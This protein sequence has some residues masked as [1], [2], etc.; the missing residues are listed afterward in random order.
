MKLCETMAA[1]AKVPSPAC[2]AWMVQFPAASSEAVVPETVQV[3]GV[4]EAKA[5]VRPELAVA[6]R[7]SVVVATWRP[8]MAGKLMLCACPEV[9][10]EVLDAVRFSDEF[11]ARVAVS[12]SLLVGAVRMRLLKVAE[13]P[14]RLAEVVPPSSAALSV[15]EME[16]VAAAATP[17]SVRLTTGEGEI[18]APGV[19]RAGDEGGS[20][21]KDST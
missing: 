15:I 7:P 9:A 19:T 20:V 12:V 16:L 5:T 1:A 18:A 17:F 14:A 4:V 10:K 6:L 8:P 13:P 3:E 11:R 21:V 2:V